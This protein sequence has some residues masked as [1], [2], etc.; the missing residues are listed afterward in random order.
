MRNAVFY[1]GSISNDVSSI[2]SLDVRRRKVFQHDSLDSELFEVVHG[3]SLHATH[4]SADT[5]RC[6]KSRLDRQV[7]D[8]SS[9]RACSRT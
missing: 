9:H 3:S 6:G 4:T 2:G 1:L 5:I 7:N 8:D